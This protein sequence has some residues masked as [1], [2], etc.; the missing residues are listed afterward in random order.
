[1]IAQ[2]L[3]GTERCI[4]SDI[5]VFFHQREYERTLFLGKYSCCLN[6]TFYTSFTLSLLKKETIEPP[7][8]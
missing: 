6:I 8:N 3:A 4:L 2:K 1:L 5:N 7:T